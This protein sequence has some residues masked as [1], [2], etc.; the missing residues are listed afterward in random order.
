MGQ[1]EG[2]QD[3]QHDAQRSGRSGA[4][5]RSG[6]GH[7]QGRRRRARP[8]RRSPARRRAGRPSRSSR[9]AIHP[10][11][12]SGRPARAGRRRT[13]EPK[14]MPARMPTRLPSAAISPSSARASAT[15]ARR[16]PDGGLDRCREL[17]ADALR[18]VLRRGPRR[19]SLGV[20]QGSSLRRGWGGRPDDTRRTAGRH[21]PT[22]G[23]LRYA[24]PVDPP[25]PRVRRPPDG[26]A[27]GRRR[28]ADRRRHPRHEQR[29]ARP[30]PDR[31]RAWRSPGSTSCPIAWRSS[32]GPSGR[33]SGGP[34]WSCRP[35]AWDPTPDDLTREAI[36]LVVGETPV[37]DP[38]LEA[39]LREPVGPARPAVPGDQPQAGLA[40][41]ERVGRWPIR[42]APRP[43]GG[44]IG[45]TDGWWSCCPARPARCA[46][47]GSSTSCPACSP[48][49]WAVA[50]A[51]GPCGSP[52]SANR[53]SPTCSARRS[54]DAPIPRSRPMPGPTRSM[55]GSPLRRAADG[56]PRP[57]STRPRLSSSIAW[58]R[59]SGLAA[60]RPGGR[61]SRSELERLGWSLAIVESGTD[62]SLGA[63]LAGLAG[64]RRVE[65]QADGPRAGAALE[66]EA[67]AVAAHS[68]AEVGLLVSARPRG[69][70]TAVSVAIATPRGDRHERRLGFLSGSA[71]RSR[72]ALIAAA[73][74]LAALRSVQP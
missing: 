18:R 72:A 29:R 17:L 55:S 41:S 20:V 5:R 38:D 2:E 51:A 26:R 28:R 52:G 13:G 68:G 57:S 54:C 9:T 73:A 14:A 1:V 11:T 36:A 31:G 70:D 19:A 23:R 49:V 46:R 37:V 24:A 63:L 40:D 48:G 45:R 56:R 22:P 39:W 47:C 33:R 27:P 74:L 7:V 30:E 34:T 35:A 43:A 60:A 71:G 42:T 3:G 50:C 25:P 6:R 66:A 21:P 16:D 12:G 69:Q 59:M 44:S 58:G 64:L 10:G 8:R 4:G 65:R 61:R 32:P 15:W 62:G 53:R 67:R